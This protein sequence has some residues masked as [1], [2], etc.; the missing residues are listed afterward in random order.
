MSGVSK[1]PSVAA[2]DID[3]QFEG[4]IAEGHLSVEGGT[5][6]RCF[7]RNDCRKVGCMGD[8]GSGSNDIALKSECIVRI[9]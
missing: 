5:P 7:E 1:Y 6:L 8:R 9:D 4:L 3:K 2:S